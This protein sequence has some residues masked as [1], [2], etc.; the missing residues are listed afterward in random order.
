MSLEYMES[1]GPVGVA[2]GMSGNQ[3]DSVLN[4]A[5]NY[6][7]TLTEDILTQLTAYHRPLER[8][9]G[10]CDALYAQYCQEAEALL[11]RPSHKSE[12]GAPAVEALAALNLRAAKDF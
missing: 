7:G 4:F 3:G 11:E 10:D 1:A 5:K 8:R 12:D 9:P 2:H 6:A